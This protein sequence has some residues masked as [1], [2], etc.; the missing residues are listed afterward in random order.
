MF[1]SSTNS[2]RYLEM[3]KS[4]NK[5]LKSLFLILGNAA[6][7]TLAIIVSPAQG[8]LQTI[9]VRPLAPP[10]L[11]H[12]LP[13]PDLVASQLINRRSGPTEGVLEAPS[14]ASGTWTMV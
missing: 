2:Y 8:Y 10:P 13:R 5:V 4:L 14:A 11:R 9:P 6:I 1:S 7:V 12:H 3:A